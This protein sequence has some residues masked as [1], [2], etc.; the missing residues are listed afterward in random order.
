MTG[1][2]ELR[3]KTALE[4]G[5]LIRNKEIS[6]P[7]ATRVFLDA[8]LED[9]AKAKDDESKINAFISIDEEGAINRAKEVQKKIDKGEILSPLSGVPVSVKDNVCIDGGVTTG[10]SHYLEGFTPPYTATVINK[11]SEAGCI[12]IGKT[13][14]DE[15][16]MGLGTRTSYFGPTRNPL[17]T[18]RIPGGSSGGSAAAVAGGFSPCA[19][20]SDTGGSIRRPAAFTGVTGIKPTYGSV[21][22]YGVLAY[23]SS[24]DQVGP[25][26]RDARDCA[27]LLSILSGPDSRDSTS[28][29]EKPFEFCGLMHGCNGKSDA[30][31]KSPAEKIA[32]MKIAL[33][34]NY[35]KDGLSDDV[36][37][38]ILSAADGLKQLGASVEEIELPLVEYAVP[39]YHT[40]ACAEA[41]SNIARF[42]GIKYGYRAKGES[43]IMRE[44]TLSRSEGFGAEVKKQIMLGSF[45][46][47]S[48]YYDV[49]FRKAQKVRSLI[50]AEL[51][52]TL[53]KYDIILSP[54]NATVADNITD[55]SPDS[56][57]AYLSG[58]Y[59]VSVDLAGLPA[60]SLPCGTGEGSMPVGMQLIGR[61]FEEENILTAA[62]AWQDEFSSS[63]DDFDK[64]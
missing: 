37:T 18:T 8:A 24:M 35:L 55:E 45:V 40:I 64:R 33:P 7:E 56:L 28:V 59:T 52:R 5:N 15:F 26:G 6:S 47:S 60:V 42:D 51:D 25:I 12:I 36:R 1:M 38:A 21:S 58:K 10:G 44:Y 39:T 29:I 20:A 32:G 63:I 48:G 23:A 30:P 50:K 43:D 49:Y 13:N 46:L 17:D 14:M 34:V 27:V 61:H 22:R 31:A 4:I 54:V 11:I 19:V 16:A 57:A 53:D 9:A 2:N 62:C 3:K 41:S